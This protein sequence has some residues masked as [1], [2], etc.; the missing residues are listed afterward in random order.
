METE[1]FKIEKPMGRLYNEKIKTSF[2]VWSK[3]NLFQRFLLRICF[4]FKYKKL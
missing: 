3:I 1:V 2:Q 4:G